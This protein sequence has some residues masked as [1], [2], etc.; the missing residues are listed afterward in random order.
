MRLS[1]VSQERPASGGGW[2]LGCVRRGARLREARRRN[3]LSAGLSAG[4]MRRDSSTVPL[5]QGS[6]PRELPRLM[7]ALALRRSP[8][9]PTV[10]RV[11]QLPCCCLRDAAQRRLLPGKRQRWKAPQ[12]P[13]RCP[14]CP[15]LSRGPALCASFAPP[16]H[17][18]PPRHHVLFQRGPANA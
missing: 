7:R 3:N 8:P 12:P 16:P 9:W 11:R 4:A 18:R 10:A 5:G 2:K 15:A 17:R 1:C 13:L 14:S 6:P